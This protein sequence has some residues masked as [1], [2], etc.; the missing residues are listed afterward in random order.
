MGRSKGSGVR[1]KMPMGVDSGELDKMFKQMIGTDGADITIAYPRYM[2]IKHLC[3]DLI[4]LVQL[5]VKSP[6]M[7]SMAN[8]ELISRYSTELNEWS[9]K[10]TAQI[11]EIFSIDLAA[12]EW[13]FSTVEDSVRVEFEGIYSKMKKS[14]LVKQ[15]VL[16][17][18]RLVPY[19]KPIES[20]DASF[21]A[22]IPGLSWKPMPFSSFDLKLIFAIDKCG[23]HTR[24]F[25]MILLQKMLQFSY[26]L[27]QELNS[28]DIDIKRFAAIIRTGLEETQKRPEFSRCRAAF[29]AIIDS[30]DMLESNFVEY[31]RDFVETGDSSVIMHS[32]IG[33]VVKNSSNASPVL[34][35][36]FKTIMIFYEKQTANTS[37]MDPR[38][39]AMFAKVR[40][41]IESVSSGTQNL[42]KGAAAS[43]E[44]EGVGDMPDPNSDS[45]SDDCSCGPSAEDYSSA[46]GSS[47]DREFAS[48]MPRGQ[49]ASIRA[50]FDAPDDGSNADVL[51]DPDLDAN[52]GKNADKDT[53]TQ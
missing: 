53:N 9:E 48:D 42:S 24:Q 35:G 10:S 25:L 47:A 15:F 41:S 32:F 29:K 12:H 30:I 20:G 44:C 39:R 14:I 4:Q 40:E 26:K 3:E 16:L 33:D 21:V 31:Y 19:K 7:T 45:D 38:M 28:P 8:H 23:T 50:A 34:L 17:C 5:L 37:R 2:T 36:Q 6:F 43:A 22:S 13:D 46:F 1:V 52:V 11:N 27:W 18:D 49:D 51:A